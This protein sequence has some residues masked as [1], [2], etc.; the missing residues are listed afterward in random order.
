M[1]FLRFIFSGFWIWCG[2]VIILVVLGEIIVG[3]LQVIF[4]RKDKNNEQTNKEETDE[5]IE[6]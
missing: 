1:E 3:S 5:E 4:G 6:L 2:F